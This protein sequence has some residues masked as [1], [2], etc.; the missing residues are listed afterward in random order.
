M[1][2]N[3]PECNA[4]FGYIKK[5]FG[6]YS[7]N[8]LHWINRKVLRTYPLIEDFARCRDCGRNV[9]DFIVP[10]ELWNEVITGS[11]IIYLSDGITPSKEGAEGVW[12]YDCFCNR[13]DERLGIKWRMDLVEKWTKLRSSEGDRQ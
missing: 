13:A 3:C 5:M 10:N 2:L 12:C 1:V 4:G 11:P 9:H 8:I 7:W 6:I